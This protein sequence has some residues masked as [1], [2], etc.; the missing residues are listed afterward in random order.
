MTRFSVGPPCDWSADQLWLVT[1]RGWS[2]PMA[3]GNWLW[4]QKGSTYISNQWAMTRFLVK[5]I[6]GMFQ[7][8]GMKLSSQE[9]PL[10][11][12]KSIAFMVAWRSD[13][14]STLKYK[15]RS[16]SNK[17]ILARILGMSVFEA[18]H[19]KPLSPLLLMWSPCIGC[20][21][22]PLS[23]SLIVLT[24]LKHLRSFHALLAYFMI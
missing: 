2:A 4:I 14:H 18:S 15:T 12:Q 5:L 10:A 3:T 13:T 19:W 21:S 20:C 11:T 22:Y 17:Q 1:K 6:P 7:T 9:T 23:L 8:T 16:W 24:C